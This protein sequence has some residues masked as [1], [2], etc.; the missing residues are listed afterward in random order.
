[1]TKEIKKVTTL[2]KTT[3]AKKETPIK[4]I[5]PAGK[6]KYDIYDNTGKYIRTYSLKEHGKDF[7][8][9]AKGFCDKKG[10]NM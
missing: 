9:L 4:E 3:V 1:M 10:F 2:K 8:K 5:K 6:T 7:K